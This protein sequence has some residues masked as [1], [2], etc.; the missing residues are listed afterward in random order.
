MQSETHTLKNTRARWAA[1]GAAI[2]VSIG[3]GGVGLIH[4]TSPD[5]ATAFVPIEPCRL[6]DTRQ[7]STVGPRKTPL[8]ADETYDLAATGQQGNCNLPAEASGVVLNVTA[9]GA[10]AATYLTLWPSGADRPTAS[11]LN[12]APGAAPTPNAVTTDLNAD[13]K[14][15]IYNRFGSVDVL[16]DAVGYYVE[17]NHDD[18][19]YTQAQIDEQQADVEAFAGS[20]FQGFIDVDAQ[21][22]ELAGTAV[23][24]KSGRLEYSWIDQEAA[25][26]P[27]GVPTV[28][29][30]VWE[31]TTGDS[32]AVATRTATGTYSVEFPGASLTGGSVQVSAYG[33]DA[34]ACQ[35][36]SWGGD[37]I[38]VRCYDFAGNPAASPFT[39]MHIN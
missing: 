18:R 10:T 38:Y 30:G 9:V 33:G 19:Y 24:S 17:H 6:F 3:A 15:S 23:S 27:I 26:A 28:L 16:A 35:V 1:V 32:P 34:R 4:A 8:G 14:F 22:K 21:L 5:G 13:G 31:H 20:V 2:A 29:G 36:S 37:T 11:A 25:E 7:D 39:V 12:P